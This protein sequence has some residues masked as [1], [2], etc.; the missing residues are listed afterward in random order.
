MQGNSPDV[1]LPDGEHEQ[2]H[3]DEAQ[4]GHILAGMQDEL[5]NRAASEP[6]QGAEQTAVLHCTDASYAGKLQ[7]T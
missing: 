7:I 3:D 2:L 4:F 6:V 5:K 1:R